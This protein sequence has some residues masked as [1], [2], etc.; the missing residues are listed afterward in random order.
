M[1]FGYTSLFYMP[2][3]AKA[4]TTIDDIDFESNKDKAKDYATEKVREQASKMTS[5]GKQAIKDFNEKNGK[6]INDYL[7][8]NNG[9]LVPN[10]PENED[11]KRLD[12]TIQNQTIGKE[13]KLYANLPI[14]EERLSS[15]LGKTVE[16]PHYFEASLH[17]D[18]GN[19]PLW[20]I[21]ANKSTHGVFTNQNGSAGIILERGI[22]IE[23]TSIRK[24]TYM[25][26]PRTIVDAKLISKKDFIDKKIKETSQQLTNKI[27]VPISLKFTGT[28][29]IDALTRATTFINDVD[30]VF[31]DINKAIPNVQNGKE[32]FNKLASVGVTITLRDGSVLGI[33]GKPLTSLGLFRSSTKEI[34]INLAQANSTTLSHELGHAIDLILLQAQSIN[35]P[36]FAKIFSQEK[37]VFAKTFDFDIDHLYSDTDIAKRPAEYWAESFAIF[38]IDNAKLKATTP[39][40]YQYI[41]ETLSKLLQ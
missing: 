29:T 17:S 3:T 10:D 1:G 26:M 39:Q 23:V 36:A 15:Y 14:S 31:T 34:Q 25:G 13:I 28:E 24:V 41:K 5:V 8:K 9:K 32:L 7:L 40:T 33:D 4:E 38:M 35:D 20:M 21:E 27:K 18:S 37:E 22:G 16:M 2:L 19:T 6:S 11:I 12:T 30:T